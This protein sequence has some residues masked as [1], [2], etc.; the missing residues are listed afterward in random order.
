MELEVLCEVFVVVRQGYDVKVCMLMLVEE[1]CDC[2]FGVFDMFCND[3]QINDE[4]EQ[5]GG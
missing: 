5:S 2:S 3:G 1:G 4:F